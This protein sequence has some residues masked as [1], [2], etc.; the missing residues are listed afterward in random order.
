MHNTPCH[1]SK[2]TRTC[3]ECNETPVL[4][5]PGNLPEMNSIE[6]ISKIMKNDIGN[7]LSCIKEEMWT[8]VKHQ[9]SWKNLK[10]QFQGEL[11]ILSSKWRCNE[12][13]EY[14]Q[15]IPQSQY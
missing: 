11:Q 3:L 8:Y 4:K 13:S 7:Q 2:R 5:F 6:K 12:N 14:D 10:I 15:E 9:T 1:N